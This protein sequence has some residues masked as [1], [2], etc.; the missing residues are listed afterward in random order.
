M[1]VCKDC[2][3][4]K[5]LSEFHNS[6][7]SKDGKQAYCK[8]CQIVRIGK[9]PN[10]RANVR[11]ATLKKLYGITPEDYDNLFK[12]QNGVC[13]ICQLPELTKR[14]YL[15]VDH[16]HNTGIVRGLL[17]YNCNTALGKFMDSK[18]NLRSAIHYLDK[19]QARIDNKI[20][21]MLLNN[22]EEN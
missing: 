9:S 13:D 21:Q 6:K 7:T 15:C 22:M 5:A 12:K 19:T 11:K 18:D 3:T 20:R 17:C 10:Q 16:D 14:E 1:K 2:Q 4:D 8:P